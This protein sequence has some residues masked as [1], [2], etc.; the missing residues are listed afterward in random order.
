MLGLKLTD[1]EKQNLVAYMLALERREIEM[2]RILTIAC[3]A[4]LVAGGALAQ[5]HPP[6]LPAIRRQRRPARRTPPRARR[7]PIS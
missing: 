1:E 7:L 4:V 6:P 3:I 2:S 5:P